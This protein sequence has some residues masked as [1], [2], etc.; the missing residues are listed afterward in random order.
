MKKSNFTVLLSLFVLSSLLFVACEKDE[1]D[2]DMEEDEL[3]ESHENDDVIIE[4]DG[5][6]GDKID[7]ADEAQPTTYK[8]GSYSSVGNYNSPAGPEEVTVNL[9]VN[10]DIVTAVTITTGSANDVSVKHQELFSDGIASLVNGVALD[11][12]DNVGAVNGSSLT[13]AAFDEAV[14]AIK[15][16]A[17]N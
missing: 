7:E 17:L 10:E 14:A 12:I 1:L 6:P 16:Q 8:D 3:M 9:T 2:E 15:T 11:E 13:G 5:K 4:P